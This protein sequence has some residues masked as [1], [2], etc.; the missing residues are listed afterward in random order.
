M[1]DNRNELIIEQVRIAVD[2]VDERDPYAPYVS[3][4]EMFFHRVRSTPDWQAFAVPNADDTG[5]EW[6]TWEQTGERVTAIAAGLLDLG[7]TRGDRLALLSSTRLE[8]I[9]V[10]IAAN[11]A[12]AATTTVYPT[13]EAAD[14]VH[15]VADSGSVVFVAEN[16]EQAA[17]LDGGA[18]SVKHV[19]LIDGPGE[20]TLEVLEE[21]GRAALEANPTLVEDAIATIGADDL[22]SIIYTSGTTG[23]PRGVEL[24]HGGW[25]WQAVAQDG[26]GVF[27]S[28]MLHYLWL[29]LSHSFGKS[30]LCGVM[31][32][33]VPTYVDGRVDKIIEMLPV[34]KPRLMCAAPRIF[35]KAYNKAV[36]TALSGGPV[37]AK[38]FEWAVSVGKRKV[39]TGKSGFAYAIAER[40]VFSKLQERLGGK[41]IVLVS[42]AAPLG[43][44]IAE[45]FAAAGLPILEGYGLTEA[46]AVS[47][48]N[49]LGKIRVGT[50]GE[51]LGNLE[52]KFDE[53]GE[54]LL[55]GRSI[56]RAYHNLPEETAAAFTEDGW[57]R[58]GDIGELD[59]DG[60]L[61][62]TDRKKDLVKTSGGKYIAPSAIEN[63]FKAVCPY[64]SQAVI[65]SQA[66]NFVTM[67]VTLDEE[68]IV[69]WAGGKPYAEVVAAPETQKM[70]AGYVD[71]LNAKLN[72]W[73]TVK[74][75][76]ILPRDLSIED[77]E[78][79]PSMKIKRRAVETAFAEQIDAMY[80]GTVAKV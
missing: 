2:I 40:L 21:R 13:T 42:G 69:K 34:V 26:V 47:F 28:D 3:I 16:A 55:R 14:A 12:G 61:T 9:L 70:I 36:T 50:V 54:L 37:K 20:F 72:R 63:Q 51:R 7:V 77:G 68:S 15:I 75:F 58:S 5:V 66:R 73:E 11:C 57:L 62:I 32:I 22:A 35:E 64:V 23:R 67:L 46:S 38:I 71:Q 80:E 79:T 33:G 53:D 48:V 10:D 30:L 44:E 59:A 8:W 1:Y 24:T 18:T 74:K 25:V 6:L 4:P 29:P 60:Y 76:A 45:F 65:V 52:V 27:R 41:G 78:I 56:M 31:H 49:R 17:K 39:A 19:V 43:R